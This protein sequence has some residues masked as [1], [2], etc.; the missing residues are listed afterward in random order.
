MCAICKDP[1]ATV[2]VDPMREADGSWAPYSYGE[3]TCDCGVYWK[4]DRGPDGYWRTTGY[5]LPDTNQRS[6][7][8]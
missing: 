8:E 2:K 5:I 3:F 6:H 1:N 4:N 7:A